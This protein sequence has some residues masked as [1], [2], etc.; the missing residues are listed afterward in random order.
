[1]SK[2]WQNNKESF[3]VTD[4]RELRGSCLFLPRGEKRSCH[5]GGHGRTAKT[6]GDC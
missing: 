6:D 3:E 5:A 2:Q 4:V 1:M